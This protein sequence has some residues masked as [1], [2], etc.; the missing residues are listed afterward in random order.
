MKCDITLNVCLKKKRGL[1]QAT[2]RNNYCNL[3]CDNAALEITE[4]Q[5]GCMAVSFYSDA[6][7]FMSQHHPSRQRL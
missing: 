3:F 2:F 7:L 6:A 1:L 4:Q 5:W